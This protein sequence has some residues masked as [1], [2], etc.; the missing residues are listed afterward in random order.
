MAERKTIV[1]GNW[2]MNKTRAEAVSFVEQLSQSAS[3]LSSSTQILLFPAFVHLD[4]CRSVLDAA[5]IGIGAQ[6]C[7]H[8][9]DGAFTGEISIAMLK[10]LRITHTLIGHSE[11]RRFMSI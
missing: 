3:D 6:N 5:H 11:R 2:K 1:A 4:A 8:E 7:S 9:P 10:D